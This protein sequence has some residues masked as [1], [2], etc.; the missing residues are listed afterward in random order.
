M[1]QMIQRN[2]P[3]M[4]YGS[5]SGLSR[6]WKLIRHGQSGSVVQSTIIFPPPLFCSPRCLPLGETLRRSFAVY[7]YGISMRGFAKCL[8]TLRAGA[9][10]AHTRREPFLC[11]NSPR[12]SVGER[13]QLSRRHSGRPVGRIK[14]LNIHQVPEKEE[15]Q[16]EPERALS[17]NV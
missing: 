13:A 1:I 9:T 16:D 14:F 2:Y 15:E 8:C 12:C 10:L 5:I 4:V 7:V 11:R 3:V 17:R 6:F